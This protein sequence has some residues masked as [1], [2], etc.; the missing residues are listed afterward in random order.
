M[1][2]Y[3]RRA[4]VL[5]AIIAF[6]VFA[7]ACDRTD[8]PTATPVST[9]TPVV[10]TPTPTAD[11]LIKNRVREIFTAQIDAIKSDDWEAVYQYCSPSYK[12]GR[13]LEVFTRTN[14]RLFAQ[15]GYTAAGFEARNVEPSI[16]AAGRVRVKWDAFQDG[17][18]VRTEEVGQVYLLVQGRWYDEGAWCR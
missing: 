7:T 2:S 12:S 16:R 13:T 3:K 4:Q 15:D 11:T 8:P 9:P 18:F 17:R 6:S 14:A 1:N 5:F 10:G